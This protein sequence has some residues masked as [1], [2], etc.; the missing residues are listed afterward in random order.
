MTSPHSTSQRLPIASVLVAIAAGELFHLIMSSV[1]EVVGDV[2][3][4]WL[5][6]LLRILDGAVASGVFLLL[7]WLVVKLSDPVASPPQ[8][9]QF[10]R[11]MRWGVLG[12]L[13]VVVFPSLAVEGIA[14]VLVHNVLAA[15][16]LGIGVWSATVVLRVVRSYRT[17]RTA[18]ALRSLGWVLLAAVPIRWIEVTVAPGSLEVVYVFQGIVVCVLVTLLARRRRWL[19]SLS[20]GQRWSLGWWTSLV[21][22]FSIVA[23]ATLFDS[24]TV[25]SRALR[26]WLTGSELVVGYVCLALAMYSAIALVTIVG[27]GSSAARKTFE[28]DAITFFNRLVSEHAD[29]Q[30]LYDTAVTLAV[31]LTE[32]TG[33]MLLLHEGDRWEIAALAGL[34]YQ[35]A[36]ALEIQSVL[37]HSLSTDAVVVPWLFEDE[38][39]FRIAR[40]VE[41][42]A[43]SLMLVPLREGSISY[44]AIVVV[45]TKPFAF[46]QGDI[47]ALGAFAPAVTIALANQRLL[48]SAIERERLRRELMLGREIQKKLLPTAAPILNGWSVAGWSE[49][50]LEVG[51]DYFDYFQLGD[52]T[53]CIVVADVSGKGISAAFYMAKLKG[54]CLALAPLCRSVHDFIVRIH[55]ALDGGVLESRVYITLAAVG[56]TPSGRVHIVRAGHPPPVGVTSGGQVQVYS[57]QGIALGMVSTDRFVALTPVLEIEQTHLD[58]LL[59]F[60]D[61][62]LEAGLPTTAELGLDGI[63]RMIQ[64]HANNCSAE[65]LLQRLKGDLST[66]LAS[67]TQHDD[68]TMVIMKRTTNSS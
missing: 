59:L 65:E 11:W 50:A 40:S 48:R 66:M 55:R 4:S 67:T 34:D 37:G 64:S 58:T 2:V 54:I 9:E 36:A 29:S 52:G 27:S 19:G 51:G 16:L 24:S 17:A 33:A 21:L 10:E 1:L 3:P 23:A 31:A 61:G 28:F 38:R 46:E 42:Y 45:S 68:I 56:I 6:Q 22:V 15:M 60:S 62:Y 18:V 26:Q 44:G 39:F 57:P 43:Q 7:V 47:A 5:E 49:P 14:A 63:R 13:A 41:S 35:R 12:Y 8:P 20:R 25:H 32:S 30:Q 53:A